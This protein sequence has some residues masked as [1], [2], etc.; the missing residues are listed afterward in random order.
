MRGAHW[1][2]PEWVISL[3]F[4]CT[5]LWHGFGSSLVWCDVLISRE[6]VSVPLHVYRASL[7]CFRFLGSSDLNT[8]FQALNYSRRRR[9]AF[10]CSCTR[11]RGGHDGGKRLV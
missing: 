6:I 3:D 9:F 8:L 11:I 10:F 7:E 2:V 5:F 1:F 4:L